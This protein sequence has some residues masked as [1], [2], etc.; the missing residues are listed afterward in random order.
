MDSQH[1]VLDSMSH[2]VLDIS[3]TNMC[4]ILFNNNWKLRKK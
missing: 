1:F 2:R 3:M 4:K